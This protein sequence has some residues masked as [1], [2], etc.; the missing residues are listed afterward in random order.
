MIYRTI[1][2][3]QY[4]IEFFF[5]NILTFQPFTLGIEVALSK[6]LPDL[7]SIINSQL[8]SI[9]NKQTIPRLNICS[10]TPNPFKRSH[11]STYIIIT[12]Q[13]FWTT[14]IACYVTHFINYYYKICYLGIILLYN[15]LYIVS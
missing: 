4:S 8:T 13:H 11:I 12:S 2:R 14:L 9:F 5:L 10:F 6:F 1:L 15:R 7:T 3:Q